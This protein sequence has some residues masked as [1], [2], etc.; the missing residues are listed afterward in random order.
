[1]PIYIYLNKSFLLDIYIIK[2]AY[3][4]KI[5]KNKII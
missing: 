1:M 3:T 2:Y 4:F 5:K